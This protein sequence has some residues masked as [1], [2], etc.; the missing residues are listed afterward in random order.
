VDGDEVV[1]VE[2]EGG[3]DRNRLWK[4]YCMRGVLNDM[5]IMRLFDCA[6]YRTKSALFAHVF[7]TIAILNTALQCLAWRRQLSL[8]SNIFRVPCLDPRYCTPNFSL[9]DQAVP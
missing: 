1:V 5:A 9:L 2:G 8:M 6:C 3:L 4:V 7:I